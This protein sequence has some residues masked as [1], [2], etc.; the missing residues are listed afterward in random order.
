MIALSSS[1]LRLQFAAELVR[2]SASSM[3]LSQLNLASALLLGLTIRFI[4]VRMYVFEV[5]ID[6]HSRS[7]A[8][9]TN[10]SDFIYL[11][12]RISIS[13]SIDTKAGRE[14]LPD[15][16]N[17]ERFTAWF[18]NEPETRCQS[19]SEGI[20]ITVARSCAKLLAINVERFGDCSERA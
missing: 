5:D 4:D 11:I 15:F 7:F 9:T 8:P 13:T 16:M 1:S 14:K 10:A 17:R 18:D 20:Q 2:I 3:T 12:E 19:S 6:R